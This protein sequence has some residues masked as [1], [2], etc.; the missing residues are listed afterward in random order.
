MNKFEE[1]MNAIKLN[2][3][4][5][6]KDEKKKCTL[7]W[8]FAIIGALATIAAIAYGVYKHF[9]PDYLEDFEEDEYDDYDDEDFE[10]EEF[11]EEFEDV[12]EVVEQEIE[13]EI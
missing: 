8:V 6:K 12:Q 7:L 3:L 4:M 13:E 9:T 11:E 1:L 5:N 2:E 10:E